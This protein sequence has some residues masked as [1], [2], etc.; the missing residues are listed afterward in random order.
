MFS[1]LRAAPTNALSLSPSSPAPSS[2]TDASEET[3]KMS[4][5]FAALA[6]T[7]KDHPEPCKYREDDGGYE[8]GM[9]QLSDVVM[10]GLPV[11][12]DV[13][14]YE[15]SGW[16]ETCSCPGNKDIQDTTHIDSSHHLCDATAASTPEYSFFGSENPPSPATPSTPAD[17]LD[18][19]DDDDDDDGPSISSG[20][21]DSVYRWS[22]DD[23]LRTHTSLFEEMLSASNAALN[24][25]GTT[26]VPACDPT[27]DEYRSN[28]KTTLIMKVKVTH[29][30]ASHK[31]CQPTIFKRRLVVVKPSSYMRG[32]TCCWQECRAMYPMQRPSVGSAGSS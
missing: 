29:T 19:D 14:D 28:A 26:K 24:E 4:S 3:L 6:S 2:P 5:D 1:S 13:D 22:H 7:N 23:E 16:S 18:D 15:H 32:C 12:D 27:V 21:A 30:H 10:S 17:E 25:L 8:P 9:S 20:D 11:D 31:R